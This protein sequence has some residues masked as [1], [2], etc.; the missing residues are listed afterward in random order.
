M[1]QPSPKPPTAD[2]LRDDIDHGLTGE[3]VPGTDPA[4]APLGTDAEA[5]GS[6]PTRAE[7]E[8]EQRNRPASLPRAAHGS[9]R[10]R[11]IWAACLVVL[12]MLVL[13]LLGSG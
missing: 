7:L 11:W 3:E 12:A 13:A 1:S 8:L 5:G 6:P 4:A 2:R 10:A 9:G